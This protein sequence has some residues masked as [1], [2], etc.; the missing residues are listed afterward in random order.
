MKHHIEP[1]QLHAY[2]DGALSPDE[3]LEV[4]SALTAS[5]SLRRQLEAFKAVKQQVKKTYSQFEPPKQNAPQPLT[6]QPKSSWWF[7]KSAVASLLLGFVIGLG[8]IELSPSPQTASAIVQQQQS[9][10]YLVHIDSD[11]LDKQRQAIEE[12][13]E[14]LS[15]V[16]STIHV[17]LISNYKGVKLFDVGNPNHQALQDLLSKYENLTLFACKRA[18]ERAAESGEVLNLIPQVQH[19]K[20]AIDA[21]VERLN[22]GWSYI[23]I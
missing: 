19:D 14:L 11:D 21:V 16:D 18:L 7:P 17:D 9:E 22:S 2:L 12:I 6:L 4:E 20:P 5:E 10:N 13:S 8:F 23:K 1:F 15:T 3:C